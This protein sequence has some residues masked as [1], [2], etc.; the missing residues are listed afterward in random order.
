M[1]G[2]VGN[3]YCI[4]DEVA[5]AIERLFEER[6]DG[7]AWRMYKA[8]CENSKKQMPT[9]ERSDYTCWRLASIDRYKMD[10][11]SQKPERVIGDEPLEVEVGND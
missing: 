7:S 4:Y 5:K 11:C 3:V 9:F 8:F 1:N 6:T 2:N 10:I